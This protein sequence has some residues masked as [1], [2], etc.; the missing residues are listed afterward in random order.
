M[1]LAKERKIYKTFIIS[2]SLTIAL[3]LSAV[4]LG[5]AIRT[6]QLIYEENIIRAKSLFN[7]I[8]LTRKWNASHGGVYVEKK[9]GVKSNPYLKN[10]DIETTDGKIYTKRNPALM[11]REISEYAEKE[12]LFKFR[13]TSLKPLNP[14]NKPDAF[15]IEALKLF[16]KGKKEVFHNEDK[17][18][19]TYFRYMAPLYVEKECLQCHLRQGYKI[20]DVRGGISIA[21]D[22]ANVQKKLKTNTVLIIFFATTTTLL[23]LGLIYFFTI[24]LIKSVYEARKQIEKLATTDG[25]TEIFNRR[26]LISRFEEEFERTKRLKKELGCILLDI[27]RFKSI[28]DNY[29]HCVGDEVLKEVANR[30]KNSIRPYDIFG[31]YGG[32]EFM[33]VLPETDFEATKNLAERIRNIIKENPIEDINVTVSLGAAV[34]QNKD[35]SID[36]I[37]KRADSGLYKAKN[38]GR[39]RVGWIQ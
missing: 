16:E 33:I 8:V 10:P 12:G 29:G 37:V 36:D 9:K 27:D 20:G 23:L 17:N 22:I 38:A 7:S 3:I 39:D 28:N 35:K 4:F 18:G 14:N 15:E 5:M 30:T 31:R 25:L 34:I 21:F 24:R 32:E 19:L 2:I 26:H 13:I 11:T 6:K 1:P